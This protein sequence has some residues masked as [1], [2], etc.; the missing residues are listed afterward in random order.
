M[1]KMLAFVDFLLNIEM[2]W[3]PGGTRCRSEIKVKS[4]GK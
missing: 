4:M 3:S 2:V 1:S